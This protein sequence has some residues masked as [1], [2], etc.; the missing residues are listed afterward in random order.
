MPQDNER[1]GNRSPTRRYDSPVRARRAAET[2][3]RITTAAR[4]LFTLHG[5]AGT[6]VAAIAGRA[7]VTPQTV[8]A[9]F[10]SKGAIVRALLEQL[11]QDADAAGWAARIEAEAE[12]GRQLELFAC[13]TGS[14]LSSSRA[15]IAAARGASQDPALVELREEGDRHRRS[16]LRRLVSAMATH[17]SFRPDLDLDSAT[18][19]AWLLTGLEV[20]LAATEGCGWSESEY[21][22]WLADAL[23]QQ[24]LTTGHRT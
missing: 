19:R 23:R 14:M 24:L 18:D 20:Y 7:Q 1:A 9:T 6:T 17:A 5:F 11:E 21:A 13:W 15:V 3:R 4:E 2:R 8:Y 22:D 16:A 12:P 10:G